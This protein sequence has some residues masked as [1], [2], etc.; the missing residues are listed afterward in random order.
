[1]AAE[2]NCSCWAWH[3]HGLL[4]TFRPGQTER[5]REC[6]EATT[7]RG[8]EWGQEDDKLREDRGTG[9]HGFPVMSAMGSAD[10]TPTCSSGAARAWSSFRNSASRQAVC[11]CCRSTRARTLGRARLRS[12]CVKQPWASCFTL[13]R[14]SSDSEMAAQQSFLG[15]GNGHGLGQ[16]QHGKG[17]K[18]QTGA[19]SL[20]CTS[21]PSYV[22]LEY[23]VCTAQCTTLYQTSEALSTQPSSVSYV[24][25]KDAHFPTGHSTEFCLKDGEQ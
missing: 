1:M 14:S 17:A 16:R 9:L 10:M 5:L 13:S 6:S 23:L 2:G 21:M 22:F 12:S 18:S 19:K 8:S 7:A 11:N 3:H 20:R 4:Q 15:G 24:Q 25:K